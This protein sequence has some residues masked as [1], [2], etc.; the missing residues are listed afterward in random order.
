MHRFISRLAILAALGAS[1][2]SAAHAAP[3][4]LCFEDVPQG[5]WTMPDGSGLNFE[6]LRRVEKLTGE[7]F[8][9][10]PEPWKRCEEETRTGQM[11]GMIGAADSPK[12][13]QYSVG[14]MLKTG[15][16]DP[17]KALYE[18]RVNVFVRIGSGASWDGKTLINPRRTVV[19]QRGYFVVELLRDRG[20]NVLESIKSAEEGLRMLAADSSDVAV[21][22]GRSAEDRVRDDPRFRGKVGLAKEP[23]VTFPF[24]LMISKKK[25]AADPAR[26]EAI[27]NAIRTVRA[28]AEY[29]KLEAAHPR[30]HN[31]E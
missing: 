21:L 27:W 16:P 14:P 15:V 1:T 5:P 8:E 13:R 31:A 28:S 3:L 11:D 4:R 9:F 10:V 6:L 29:R 17:E 18:D 7:K 24:Y 30:P 2:A 22:L 19:A 26:F 23:F 12:R 25:H 20:Q